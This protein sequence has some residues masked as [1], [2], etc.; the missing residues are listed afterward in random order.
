MATKLLYMARH[1]CQHPHQHI[2]HPPI[3]LLEQNFMIDSLLLDLLFQCLTTFFFL[4]LHYSTWL[5]LLPI[6][7]DFQGLVVSFHFLL[8]AI[9]P[10]LELWHLP[11]KQQSSICSELDRMMKSWCR[12]IILEISRVFPKLQN[13]LNQSRIIL[14]QHITQTLHTVHTMASRIPGELVTQKQTPP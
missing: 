3:V 8:P 4:V 11:S 10:F 6:V 9:C 5:V 1:Q 13:R 12:W 7:F 2:A 14:L